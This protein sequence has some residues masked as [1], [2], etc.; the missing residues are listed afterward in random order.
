MFKKIK[1][2]WLLQPRLPNESKNIT[3]CTKICSGTNISG[4][5]KILRIILRCLLVFS[6]IKRFFDIHN[7]CFICIV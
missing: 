5:E 3:H 7:N 2:L 4:F 1:R 6:E